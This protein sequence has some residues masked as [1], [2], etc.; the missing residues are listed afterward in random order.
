MI[1]SVSALARGR[2]GGGVADAAPAVVV[3]VFADPS[4][5][6]LLLVLEVRQ[7]TAGELTERRASCQPEALMFRNMVKLVWKRLKRDFHYLLGTGICKEKCM[8]G[9]KCI[10]KDK[11]QCTKGYYGLHCEYC[12]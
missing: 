1:S 2:S 7:R 3:V 9:G 11:C 4:L 10:Q 8:N 5:A 12:K 6:L